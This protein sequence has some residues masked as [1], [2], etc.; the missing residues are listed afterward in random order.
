MLVLV[1]GLVIFFAI[2]L[3]PSNAA[4]RDELIARFGLTGYAMSASSRSSASR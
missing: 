2:H 3:V 1:I 4:M